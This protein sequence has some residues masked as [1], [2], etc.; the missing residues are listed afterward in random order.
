MV[1]PR[2]EE[3]CLQRQEI[4]VICKCQ[5]SLLIIESGCRA[6]LKFLLIC[7]SEAKRPAEILREQAVPNKCSPIKRV[8]T[9]AILPGQQ[10]ESMSVVGVENLTFGQR[11]S[12]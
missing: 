7:L 5:P 6:Y 3:V 12:K 10:P 11:S 9:S 8:R 4:A 2:G 1:Y